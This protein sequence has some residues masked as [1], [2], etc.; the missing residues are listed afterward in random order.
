MIVGA[1]FLTLLNHIGHASTFWLYA[2]LN[3]LFLV[4]TIAFV[5]ETRDMTLE[6]IERNLMSGKR[7]R[8]IGL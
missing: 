5:P 6:Q 1:T 7:L 3:L 2:G 8:N 4:I